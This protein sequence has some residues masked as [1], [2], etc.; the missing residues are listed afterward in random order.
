MQWG[1]F[2][3]TVFSEV[4][5]SITEIFVVELL[6]DED[7]IRICIISHSFPHSFPPDF[8]FAEVAIQ[9]PRGP[10]PKASFACVTVMFI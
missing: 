1:R 7:I 9:K 4:R 5:S 3:V 6:E 10:S 2:S 8:S